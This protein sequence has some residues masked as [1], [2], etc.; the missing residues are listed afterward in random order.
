MRSRRPPG[1]VVMGTGIVSIALLLD[2]RSTLSDI[3]LGARRRHLG[4]AGGPSARPRPRRPRPVP[5]RHPSSRRA[6][7]DRRHRS[8]RHPAD[9][10]RLGLGRRGPAH[11]RAGDLARPGA[12]GARSLAGA[13][14]RR[15]VHP[16]RRHRIAGAAG[17]VAGL[18]RAR[19]LAAVRLAGAL[20]PRP[21]LL[22]VR[23]QPLSIPPAQ[24]WDR[25]PLG[26]RRRTGDLHRHRRADRPGRAAHRRPVR[27]ARS[28]E[29]D[30]AR[31]VVP[32]DGVAAGA[33]DLRG[34]APP[35]AIQ[36][37][38]LV[39][40]VPGRH[41]RRL[42]LR[43]RHGQRRPPASPT[44]PAS[45]CGS[46]SRYGWWCSPRCSAARRASPDGEP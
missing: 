15:L 6:D 35:A 11:H 37:A 3:L 12:P 16:H 28:A 13:D 26:H 2:H 46:R 4:R 33:G 31:A 44:S 36:R 22:R 17:G 30:L 5:R 14:D 25:R 38:P 27:R 23:A 32:D 39:D 10:A 29:D 45:G 8:A 43:R 34:A 42:Q 1:A 20:L 21:R 19:R 41:V 9:A 7:L 40:R 18:R 24:R